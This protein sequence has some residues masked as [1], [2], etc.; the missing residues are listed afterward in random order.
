MVILFDGR[1]VESNDVALPQQC[2]Q[3]SVFDD[4]VQ[5]VL[6]ERIVSEHFASESGQLM[7]EAGSDPPG[8]H[9]AYGQV[10]QFTG[11]FALQGI[12]LH[13]GAQADVFQ[14]ADPQQDH[15][16][17]VVGDSSRR[18]GDIQNADAFLAGIVVVD[19][20]VTDGAGGDAADPE[21]AVF[22]DHGLVHRRGQDVD[23]VISG[24]Q[25]G[26]LQSRLFPAGSELHIIFF[27]EFIEVDPLVVF[28]ESVDKHFHGIIPLF[29]E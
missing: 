19:V 1:R 7:G 2:V 10:A 9:D 6:R 26:I 17:R 28:A 13:L 21:L 25:T 4:A 11:Q 20:V 3:I 27:A 8:A 22:I 15:H 23:R 24:C 5:F 16:D 12:V 14:F 29:A 18:V